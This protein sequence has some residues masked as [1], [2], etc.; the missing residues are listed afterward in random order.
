MYAVSFLKFLKRDKK[1][2]LNALDMPP[3]PPKLEGFEDNMPDF[4]DLPDISA[5]EHKDFKFDLPDDKMPDFGKDFDFDVP[6]EEKMPEIPSFNAGMDFPAAKPAIGQNQIA[7]QLQSFSPAADEL[8]PEMS[9]QETPRMDLTLQPQ[10]ERPRR[11]F[12]HEKKPERHIPKEVYVRADKYRTMLDGIATIRNS[13]RKSDEA[14]LKL[15]NI[16]NAKDRSFDR[17]KS[18]VEDLQKKLIFIDKTLFKGE[19]K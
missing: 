15:E 12:H 18:S 16:K 8:R 17:I 9:S 6:R 4:P 13:V 7:P 2:G 19:W 3:Q 14:L 1:Q 5:P 11:I 10:Y